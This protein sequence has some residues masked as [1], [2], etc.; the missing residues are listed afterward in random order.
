MRTLQL[1]ID[2]YFSSPWPDSA[3]G[4][5]W[6][7]GASLVQLC[8]SQRRLYRCVETKILCLTL[9]W[10]CNIFYLSHFP[11]TTYL[12]LTST[13]FYHLTL[14]FYYLYSYAFFSIKGAKICQTYH[15]KDVYKAGLL[16]CVKGPPSQ[17]W[18]YHKPSWFIRKTVQAHA[19]TL[20][21]DYT[22][23][24]AKYHPL[25][26]ASAFVLYHVLYRDYT[27]LISVISFV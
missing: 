16:K 26:C 8:Q 13:P 2:I 5:P 4:F 19:L 10:D 25:F 11:S 1:S 22:K 27:F 21:H 23:C 3:Y 15:L 24:A 18:Y 6:W 20:K 12:V 9:N 17:L 7:P 14:W